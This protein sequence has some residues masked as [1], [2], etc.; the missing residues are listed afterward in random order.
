MHFYFALIL[1]NIKSQSVEQ[2]Y[3]IFINAYGFIFILFFKKIT[4]K[5][6]DEYMQRESR[7]YCTR[8]SVCTD[9]TIHIDLYNTLYAQPTVQ[10]LRQMFV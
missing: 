7:T 5:N 1:F 9:K 6:R 10:I 4:K 8:F 2:K 3:N